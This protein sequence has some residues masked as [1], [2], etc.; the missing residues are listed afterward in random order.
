M[1]YTNGSPVMRVT[2]LASK[3]PPYVAIIHP[4]PAVLRRLPSTRKLV[5]TP[6]RSRLPYS[7]EDSDEYPI[8]HLD[9]YS[10]SGLSVRQLFP[11]LLASWGPTHLVI[12][13]TIWNPQMSDKLA[14]H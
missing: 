14:H 1:L 10:P 6:P 7:S 9:S 2:S 11:H 4:D 5:G 3:N 13:R 8:F 12:Q